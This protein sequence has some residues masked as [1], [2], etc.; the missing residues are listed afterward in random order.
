MLA[1][2]RSMPVF[3]RCEMRNRQVSQSGRTEPSGGFPVRRRGGHCGRLFFVHMY[4]KALIG[5]FERA[6]L[7]A[8]SAAKGGA[9]I[10]GFTQI[11]SLI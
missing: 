6:I 3:D 10:S 11:I 7:S 4:K 9:G 2:Y 1:V 8:S 5:I